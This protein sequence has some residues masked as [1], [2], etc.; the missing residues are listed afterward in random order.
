[1]PTLKFR[2]ASR[3]TTARLSVVGLMVALALPVWAGTRG[4]VSANSSKTYSIRLNAGDLETIAATGDG[5]IDMEVRCPQHNMVVASDFDD[6]NIPVCV[7][8]A[9]ESG[10]YTIKIINAESRAV[11]FDLTATRRN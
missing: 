7:F 10:S 4:F 8:D 1:M 3:W 9:P 6:D 11:E 2:N 5:D